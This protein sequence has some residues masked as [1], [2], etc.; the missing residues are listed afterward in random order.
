MARQEDWK[1]YEEAATRILDELAAHFGFTRVEGKQSVPGKESGTDW[2]IDAKGV[3]ENDEAF[4]IIECRRYTTS[5][6]TQEKAGA[7]AYRIK[8][9]GAKGGVF[10]TPIGVQEGARKVAVAANI[11]VVRLN[12]DATPQQFVLEFLGSLFVRPLG[13]EMK[14]EGHAP[15]V[16]VSVKIASK[17][18]L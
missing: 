18:V 4:V 3:S 14:I 16:H 15:G 9:T 13:Q 7:L 10:V 1:R 8:D 17:K 6:I 11:K 12:P 2:E 5:K